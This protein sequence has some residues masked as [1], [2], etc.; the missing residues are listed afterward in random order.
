M[1]RRESTRRTA[2]GCA[3]SKDR[4]RRHPLLV[5]TLTVLVFAAVAG[6]ATGCRAGSGEATGTVT[7]STVAGPN[8]N[9]SVTSPVL[10]GTTTELLTPATISKEELLANQQSRYRRANE[11]A[12]QDLETS[13]FA[14]PPSLQH[15]VTES[16]LIITG[17]VVKVDPARWNTP[18]GQRSASHMQFTP[19]GHEYQ[20][21][22]YV[23]FYVHPEENLKGSPRFGSPI[24]IMIYDLGGRD[25]G[26]LDEGD[27]VIVMTQYEK[28]PPG[29]WKEDAYFLSEWDLGIY[30]RVGDEYLNI[31]DDRVKATTQAI[32]D[33]AWAEQVNGPYGVDETLV[34][35]V[36]TLDDVTKGIPKGAPLKQPAGVIPADLQAQFQTASPGEQLLYVG[37][38]NRD[39]EMNAVL[40]TKNFH[41]QYYPEGW[42][43]DFD[44][45]GASAKLF[46]PTKYP[47]AA[48]GEFL[49]VIRIPDTLDFYLRL[50]DPIV[51]KEFYARILMSGDESENLEYR[52]VHLR[53]FDLGAEDQWGG[54]QPE[55]DM[56]QF[57]QTH[58]LS[59][60]LQPGDIVRV[61]FDAITWAS[62]G[63]WKVFVDRRG[64]QVANALTVERLSGAKALL[65]LL[66]SLTPPGEAEGVK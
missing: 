20:S 65:D 53:A 34:S 24:A 48:V 23:T 4:R 55:P 26:P 60:F 14:W 16:E 47:N 3:G 2:G 22:T 38:G 63:K 45:F 28:Q 42:G 35:T 56:R 50:R 52:G 27:E 61:D 33:F 41:G 40:H 32:K 30:M 31:F 18:D 43:I 11:R 39:G 64:A 19:D 59:A 36:K 7:E 17:Y 62:N 46:G 5:L 1:D 44:Y 25:T 6:H 37:A 57:L 10:F 15:F 13:D 9:S 8:T 58:R 49:D 29:N 51:G 12:H 66:T 54:D 21:F